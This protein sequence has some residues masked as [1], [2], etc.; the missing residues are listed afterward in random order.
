[1]AP[2]ADNTNNGPQLHDIIITEL[3]SEF[4]RL[5]IEG[6]DITYHEKSKNII[7]T[8]N[9]KAVETTFRMLNEAL[10]DAGIR[11]L[12]MDDKIIFSNDLHDT[13]LKLGHIKQNLDAQF[14]LEAEL[15]KDE[16]IAKGQKVALDGKI[17]MLNKLLADVLPEGVEFKLKGG[18][19]SGKPKVTLHLKKDDRNLGDTISACL[20]ETELTSGKYKFK[21]DRF[22]GQDDFYVVINESDILRK[23]TNES[24]QALS[25]N[26][27]AK[28]QK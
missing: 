25:A 23:F 18:K 19:D 4:K 21:K 2:T 22:K 17:G 1:M 6:I 5:G 3:K 14:G 7:A 13:Y 15:K 24:L 26:I 27:H 8:D 10:Q 9:G 28:L 20:S 16:V 11:T 12:S